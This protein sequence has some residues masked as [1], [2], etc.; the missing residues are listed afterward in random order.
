MG[1]LPQGTP[2]CPREDQRCCVCACASC[3]GCR[4]SAR[5]E[6]QWSRGRLHPFLWPCGSGAHVM[7]VASTGRLDVTPWRVS[8]SGGGSRF[9]HHRSIRWLCC[10]VFHG[11]GRFEHHSVSR[12]IRPTVS[13]RVN[14]GILVFTRWTS[15]GIG[16]L[17]PDPR[18]SRLDT[19]DSGFGLGSRLAAGPSGSASSRD[20][21]RCPAQ[22]RSQAATD[23]IDSPTQAPLKTRSPSIIERCVRL[24]IHALRWLGARPNVGGCRREPRK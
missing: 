16:R 1:N 14:G 18:V 10:T 17:P 5:R 7:D 2:S 3:P 20:R 6:S 9:D 21:D 23:G 15:K 19:R 11:Y 13:R 22:Y 24:S 4:L 12:S 8:I